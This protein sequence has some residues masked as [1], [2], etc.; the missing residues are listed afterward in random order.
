M[1]VH[2]YHVLFVCISIVLFEQCHEILTVTKLIQSWYTYDTHRLDR[3]APDLLSLGARLCSDLIWC[4]LPVKSPCRT[5]IDAY[6]DITVRSSQRIRAA[7]TRTY[8]YGILQYTSKRH[9]FLFMPY[10]FIVCGCCACMRCC[11]L[12]FVRC[13][14]LFHFISGL[15]L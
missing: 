7:I 1:H 15:T 2:S 12:L 3:S 8:M 14:V 13:F 5:M 11:F 9:S 10:L 6:I 4:Q